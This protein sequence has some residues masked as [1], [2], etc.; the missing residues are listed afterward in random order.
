MYIP[1]IFL[2]D[3]HCWWLAEG[4]SGR[5]YGKVGVPFWG[6][7]V[8][9]TRPVILHSHWLTPLLVRDFPVLA[10]F[11]S[12]YKYPTSQSSSRSFFFHQLHRQPLDY[13]TLLYV[14]KLFSNPHSICLA[15]SLYI[16]SLFLQETR[17]NASHL[18]VEKVARVSERVAPSVTARF[19]A[20]TSRVSLSPL[21]VVS[22][23]VVV[24]SVSPL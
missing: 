5:D 14:L 20:T 12:S 9:Q 16:T 6:L 4:G 3:L 18:Q 19:C 11:P 8:D 1:V 24:S 13:S 21:S 22:H 10:G 17:S 23:V 7:P 2:R 15:V